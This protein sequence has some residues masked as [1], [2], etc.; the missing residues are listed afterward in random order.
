MAKIVKTS[1]GICEVCNHTQ[2]QHES[3]DGCTVDG[4]DCPARGKRL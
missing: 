1:G 2:K 3:R 4:S